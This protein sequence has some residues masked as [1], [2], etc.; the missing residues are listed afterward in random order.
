MYLSTQDMPLL[1]PFV[2]HL[3]TP[4]SL[5]LMCKQIRFPLFQ[6]AHEVEAVTPVI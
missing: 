4:F 6:F 1:A 2:A 3:L 5:L